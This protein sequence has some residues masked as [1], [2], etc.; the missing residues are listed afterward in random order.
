MLRPKA[1]EVI[2]AAKEALCVP[3][4][5]R[6]AAQEQL[7][8]DLVTLEALRA[9][10]SGCDDHLAELLPD[11]PAG[12]LISIP[13]VGPLTASYYGAALGDPWRFAHADAAYRYSGLSPTSYESAGRRGTRVRISKEGSVELRQAMIA[14]GSGLS[15]HHP[16][17]IAYKRRLL[18]AGKRPMI[19]AVAVAHRGHRLA[20]SMIRSGRPY[21]HN[22][23]TS[24]VAKGRSATV[25]SEVTATT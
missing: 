14:L 16:D 20:F 11:T 17:F 25:T 12:V 23:W 8:R 15:L 21:D 6:Q 13:G 24:S 19:A 4:L 18:E 7:S 5:Q 22:Q 10:L 3:A 2:A 9:D 1:T